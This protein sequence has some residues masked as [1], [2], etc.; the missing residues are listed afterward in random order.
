MTTEDLVT[1]VTQADVQQPKT[2]Q[3]ATADKAAATPAEG[4]EKPDAAQ[5]EKDAQEASEA[6]KTLAKRKQTAQER[7]DQITRQK[8]DAERRAVL[9]EKRLAEYEKL[10]KPDPSQY[11]DL[12]A[13][14]IDK[15]RFAIN[16]VRKE[17]LAREVEDYRAETVERAAQAFSERAA[18]FQLENPDYNPQAIG[19]IINGL[20]NAHV[21]AMEILES[22]NGPQLGHYLAQHP[23]DAQRIASLPERQQI[24]ELALIEARLVQPAPVKVTQAPAPVKTV[25]GRAAPAA[26]D[27]DKMS[28]A[29]WLKWR[30]ADVKAKGLR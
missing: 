22:E 28:H 10:T 6:A 15:S 12:D 21:M 11:Q 17:E 14:D 30:E 19:P 23:R 20:P 16:Q 24:R 7:I 4:T 27:P 26:T 29:E 25:G 13:L 2:E 3:P 1:D 9:A 18:T 5:A 8:G